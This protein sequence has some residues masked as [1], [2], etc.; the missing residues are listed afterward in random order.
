M[1]SPDDPLIALAAQLGSGPVEVKE[2]HISRLA[3]AGEP[4]DGGVVLKQC[5]PVDFG[6]VDLSTREKRRAALEK[7]LAVNDRFGPGVYRQ[8]RLLS[9]EQGPDGEP[10][11]EMARLNDQDTLEAKVKRG[12]ATAADLDAVL[13][14]LLPL[15]EASERI[16]QW[17]DPAVIRQNLTENLDAMAAAEERFGVKLGSALLRCN[18]LT[19]LID[20]EGELRERSAAGFVR[21]GHGDLRAEHIYLTPVGVKIL[22]GIAFGDRLRCVDVADELCF[23]ASDLIRLSP[24]YAPSPPQEG[25][26]FGRAL[27]HRYRKRSGDPISD[28]LVELYLSYRFAVRAKVA[29][30]AAAGNEADPGP[31]LKEAAAR[32]NDAI[33]IYDL[34]GGGWQ[35]WV[36]AVFGGLSGSGKSTLAAAV[37]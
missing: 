32:A 26:E 34:C 28:Q 15:F 14:H 35:N 29:A 2:T 22:D 10:V 13:D 23:L 20:F 16:P 1:T 17:G 12:D 5:K 21:D 33:A 36:L 30:L 6:F 24:E 31:R 3:L 11:L 27:L 4:G 25:W 37:A 9:P 7:E 18:Q 8:V 19:H